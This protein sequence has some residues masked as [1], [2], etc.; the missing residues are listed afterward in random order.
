MSTIKESKKRALLFGINYI[1]Q[2][3]LRLNGCIND[4]KNTAV[5][6]KQFQG[7]KEEDIRLCTDEVEPSKVTWRF[8][9]D[10]LN[11]LAV[12]SWKE[13]LD[14]AYI[15]YSGHGSHKRDVNGDEDDGFDEGICPVDCMKFGLIDDDILYAMLCRFNPN[16]KVVCVFDCCHSGSI[17]D[18]PVC[19][20]NGKL[21]P[22]GQK[23][24]PGSQPGKVFMISGCRD[25]ETS[26]DAYIASMKA[27]GGA[28]TTVLLGLLDS[29]PSKDMDFKELQK[30]LNTKLRAAGF[31]QY[32]MLTA[33][34]QFELDTMFGVSDNVKPKQVSCE[35]PE[36]KKNG[37]PVLRIAALLSGLWAL[38]RVVKKSHQNK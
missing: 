24:K 12:Q 1:S 4:V 36:S 32:A 31:Q 21:V 30:Q 2:P 13:G 5:F 15:H 3:Q 23:P 35:L 8:M 6:L 17:V 18:L 37:L 27:Y 38:A 34:R 9:L 25:P 26:A 7:F 10:A 19:Y 16:T 11:D 28:L 14:Y 22:S 20:D 33:S 29:M